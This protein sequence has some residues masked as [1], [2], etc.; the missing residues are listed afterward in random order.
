M[1]KSWAVRGLQ[2]YSTNNMAYINDKVLNTICNNLVTY[3]ITI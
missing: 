1:A 2:L 3:Y